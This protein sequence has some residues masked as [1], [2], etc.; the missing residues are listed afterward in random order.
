MGLF[1]RFFK[2]E[3]GFDAPPDFSGPPDFSK[4][5]LGGTQDLYGG[6]PLQGDGSFGSEYGQ[7]A[8]AAPPQ[9]YQGGQS[10]FSHDLFSS[11]QRTNADNARAYAQG[12]GQTPAQQS[13]AGAITGHEA[14]LILERLDTIKAELDAIKQRLVRIDH[15]MDSSETKGPQKRYF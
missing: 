1:G 10:A 14:Q 8:G 5:P 7:K 11:N 9:G 2:K 6:D 13:Y 4:D 15:Y 3:K 12:L